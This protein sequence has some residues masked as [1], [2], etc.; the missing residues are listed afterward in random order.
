MSGRSTAPCSDLLRLAVDVC[1]TGMLAVDEAGTIVLANREV[2]RLFGYKRG[3]LL[4]QR[5]ETIL[6]GGLRGWP[7]GRHDSQQDVRARR[8]EGAVARASHATA[9]QASHAT[10][11]R[12]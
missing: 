8:D 6:P 7:V 3:E 9:L 2:E 4:H 12:K 10:G 11:L 5:I 1:R